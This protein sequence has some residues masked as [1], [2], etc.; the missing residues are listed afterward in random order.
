MKKFTLLILFTLICST[1]FSAPPT[2]LHTYTTGTT[3]SS[4]DVTDNEDAIF[5]YLGAGVDSIK[6]GTITNSDIIASAGIPVSKLDLSTIATN[7]SFTG[8]N[9]FSGANT[10]SGNFTLSDSYKLDLSNVNCSSTT[11]GL[12]LPQATSCASATAEGQLCWDTDNDALYVGNST[13][14]SIIKPSYKV[15]SLTRDTATATGTQEETG[16][17][18]QPSAIIFFAVEDT[19]DEISFGFED[20]TSHS[21]YL[22]DDGAWRPSAL[23]SI[24]DEEATTGD[25]YE[26]T[27]TAFGADGFTISWVKTGTPTGTLTVYYMAFK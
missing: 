15:G 19:S 6:D 24:K 7:V 17:G 12:L 26:G 2:R 4:S 18:F 21:I 9:T 25:R 8:N 16:V 13:S 14:A 23:T 20:G 10:L 27:V 11:E 1:S 3:I 5:N 22:A